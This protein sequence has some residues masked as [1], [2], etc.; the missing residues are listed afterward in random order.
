MI[1][2][3]IG[4]VL[5]VLSFTLQAQTILVV[6]KSSQEP[7]ELV[8]IQEKGTDKGAVT[9]RYGRA[10]LKGF[11]T[12]GE[13]IFRHPSYRSKLIKYKELLRNEFRVE[14]SEEITEMEDIVVSANRWEQYQEEIP[15]QI[16]EF[17][18]KEFERIEPSTTADLLS[19]GSQVF[20]QKSQLGGGS[21]MIR[22]FAANGV[23][24][25]IDGVRMN[26]AIYR[27]GNLQ[28]VISLDPASLEKAEVVFGPSSVVYGSDALGGVMDFH[29]KTPSFS[30]SDYLGVSSGGFGRYASASGAVS[31]NYNI[32]F[33]LPNFAS[34]SSIS[35]SKFGDLRTGSNR[36]DDFPDFGKRLEYVER[37]NNSD[38]IVQNDKPNLQRPS[39]YD[40]YNFLQ[41]L[42][43][44]LGSFM[45]FSYS[46]HYSGSS[47]IHRYDRL[48]ER[49]NNILKN[50]EWYYGPQLWQMHAFQSNFT[51]PNTF[52]DRLKL[53][54]AIQF[55]EESRYDRRFQSDILRNRKE[56][57]DILSLNVDAYKSLGFSNELYYGLEMATNKVESSAFT[58]NI[59]TNEIEALSTRYPDGGSDYS[60]AAAY[61]SIKNNLSSRLIL[62]SGVRYT[63]TKLKSK[64]EDDT[65]YNFPYNEI[66]LSNGALTG[67]LGLVFNPGNGWKFNTLVSSGFRAPNVDDV[68]KVFD[69][70]PGAVVVPNTEA[71]PEYS[72]NVEY[73][74]SK[75]IKDKLSFSFVN[76]FSF[77]RDALVR[78]PFTFNGQS[79][80]E[81]DGVLSDVFA[82]QNVGEA[83]IWGAS[84][85]GNW[86]IQKGLSMN[87][88]VTYTKGE[89]KI[90]NQPLRH[91]PPIFGEVGISMTQGK[92]TST[93][94]IK[95]SGGIAFNDLAPSERAK[96]HLYTADGALPWYTINIYNSY[97]LSDYYSINFNIENILDLHYRPYSSGISAAGLNAV[98]SFRASF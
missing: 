93:F 83:Y 43:W 92:L 2:F 98:I 79:Q 42:R 65:F 67:N 41:K 26:N 91:V 44:R 95:F 72:Y 81:Y 3:I 46:Y 61:L 54:T 16:L 77:L 17:E 33:S 94:L 35:Y 76:Y 88:S 96:P 55:V 4:F 51:Y 50:A 28:N 59:V 86:N 87:A 70:E 69:S 9:D 5:L 25:V 29:T 66:K 78:R 32:T 8:T 13:L 14:L 57:V 64:F 12:E 60:S 30:E 22:G 52:F 75:N 80:I 56:K 74:I 53:T 1:R 38:V 27:S 45:D 97:K 68:A 11:S 40:Q 39:G 71:K 49:E 37:R 47:D 34:Y 31:G 90:N 48:I 23:L 24:I 20:V 6:N 15:Q 89:D 36:S 7:V 82:E 21:P 58:E 84:L 19:I 10:E 62:N 85:Y 63:F 18:K 73:G